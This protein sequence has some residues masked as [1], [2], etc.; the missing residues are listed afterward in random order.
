MSDDST[1]FTVGPPQPITDS[2]QLPAVTPEDEAGFV[3]GAD[4]GPDHPDNLPESVDQGTSVED[5]D[6]PTEDELDAVVA[7]LDP[8]DVD[9]TGFDEADVP[10]GAGLAS[11]G[12][13]PATGGS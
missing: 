4:L 10:M 5:V 11:S 3:H 2:R 1:T 7:G 8:A 9:T 12:V 13:A 6:L